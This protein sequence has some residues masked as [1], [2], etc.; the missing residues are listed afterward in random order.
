MRKP[1]Q[2]EAELVLVSRRPVQQMRPSMLPVRPSRPPIVG[3]LL[4]RLEHV[5]GATSSAP[6][7]TGCSGAT[8]PRR[9]GYHRDHFRWSATI[10]CSVMGVQIDHV[11]GVR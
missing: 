11:K 2:L 5:T 9:R 3:C 4:S 8:S 6:T 10:F 7:P 1:W